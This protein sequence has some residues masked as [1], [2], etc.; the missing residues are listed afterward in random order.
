MTHDPTNPFQPRDLKE[1]I[2]E[3][4]N[5]ERCLRPGVC[6]CPKMPRC[7]VCNYTAHD[8]AYLMDHYLCKGRIP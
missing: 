1:Q 3:V 2:S 8:A 7:P 4:E 5:I 6:N